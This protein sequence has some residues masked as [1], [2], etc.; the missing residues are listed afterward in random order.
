MT[1]EKPNFNTWDSTPEWKIIKSA[2]LK[3]VDVINRAANDSGVS[4]RLIIS[5]LAVEQLRLFFSEREAFKKWFEPLKILGSQTQFSWGV[6]GI[7]EET[8]ILIENHLK[9]P[10]SPYYLGKEYENILDFKT[11]TL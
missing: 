9:D 8:A 3:D 1:K 6:M 11:L 10:S 5:Q 4:S 7:K 2:L